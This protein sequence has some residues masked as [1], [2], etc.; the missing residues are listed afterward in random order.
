MDFDLNREEF[1]FL[2]RQAGV[3]LTD[4]Q[5]KE[6]FGVYRQIRAMAARVRQPRSRAAEPAHIFVPGSTVP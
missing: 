3:V 5:K 1:E 4:A 6:L 2:T